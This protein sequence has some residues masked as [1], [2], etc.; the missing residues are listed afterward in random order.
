MAK[1]GGF[2][3][4]ADFRSSST[5]GLERSI[6]SSAT[7][8]CAA[9]WSVTRTVDGTRC[10]RDLM[11]S[12]A[13]Q[14]CLLLPAL[15][16]RAQA[17]SA[18]VLF[19]DAAVS[20]DATQDELQEPSEL[21]RARGLVSALDS[22]RFADRQEAAEELQG[23]GEFA[24][25]AL[26]EALNAGTLK[27]RR[28]ATV[29]LDRIEKKL[30]DSRLDALLQEPDGEA[31]VSLPD[32]SR[33]CQIAGVNPEDPKRQ[34]LLNFASILEAEPELFRL[35]QFRPNALP[36]AL[37]ERSSELAAL[38]HGRVNS[39]FPAGSYAALLLLGSDPDTR[40]PR[41]TSTNISAAL[42]DQRLSRLVRDGAQRQTVRALLSAWFIRDDI[43]AERPLYFTM[44]HG[45]KGGLER[46]RAIVEARSSRPEMI[47]AILTL[48]ITGSAED[49]LSRLEELLDQPDVLW[50][51]GGARA[52]RRVP[53]G[54]VVDSEYTV[55]TCDVALA[56]ACH[57]RGVSPNKFGMKIRRT[58][59]SLFALASLGFSSDAA[60]ETAI[61]A[62]RKEFASP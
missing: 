45:V 50:P 53:G 11:M 3:P 14:V 43:A 26:N 31:A 33:F 24:I 5:I 7:W 39:P 2:W 4:R 17:A 34:E 32:W 56:V 10:L 47:L 35:K 13:I 37:A 36:N 44:E 19:S 57:L 60:R 59:G 58:E 46:A 52:V 6:V 51:F 27:A 21:V 28:D 55:K 62:Y 40:L 49:D 15:I 22:E 38:F 42:N 48:G 23:L 18:A 41:A 1:T 61:E 16:F 8:S 30:F 9:P 12:P 54:Q 29:L 25:T 20:P